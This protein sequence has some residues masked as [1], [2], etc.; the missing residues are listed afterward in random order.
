VAV[1][2]CAL[3]IAAT[4]AARSGDAQA[5]QAGG[6]PSKLD[7]LVLASMAD[8]PHLLSM[9]R[10]D[11]TTVQRPALPIE[12]KPVP[13]KRKSRATS[14]RGPPTAA[15]L[16]TALPTA[17][18]PIADSSTAASPAPAASAAVDSPAQK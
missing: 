3:G 11:P 14:S 4:L 10:Y 9:A 1:V 12:A 17:A 6:G 2:L 5:P 13:D 16:P 15:P 18:V 8:A 7:Y